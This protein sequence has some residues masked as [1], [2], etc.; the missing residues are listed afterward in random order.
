VLTE[1]KNRGTADVLMIV[2]DGLASGPTA[3]SI[4]RSAWWP[5]TCCPSRG[6]STGRRSAA[7]RGRA[8]TGPIPGGSPPT[9][10]RPGTGPGNRER[11][12]WPFI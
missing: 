5:S 3:C 10:L 11:P 2:C 6:R 4:R 7:C 1:R 12:A 8:A 9:P